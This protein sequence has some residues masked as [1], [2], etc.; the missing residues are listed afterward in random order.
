M[1]KQNP[2]PTIKD[3]FYI[4]D[5]NR[6]LELKLP[7]KG[8]LQ[9]CFMC[10]LITSKTIAYKKKTIRKFYKK[11]EYEIR[12]YCCPHCIR[13]MDKSDKYFD[14]FKCICDDF[15]CQNFPPF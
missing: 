9:Q 2:L 11:I 5:T 14:Y 13:K 12:V 10:N 4:Y 6:D 8:W 15:L 1:Y 3:V 7:K